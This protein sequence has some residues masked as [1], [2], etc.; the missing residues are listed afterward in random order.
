MRTLKK[1]LCLVLALVMVLGLCAVSVSAT[2][3]NDD[4]SIEHK[5]AVEVMSDLGVLN[6]MGDGT[7]APTDRVTR[8]Q[9]A[10]MITMILQ[11]DVD[12]SAF[13]GA[14]TDLTDINGHWAEAY[15][16][17]CVSQGIVAGRGDGTFDPDNYVT[18]SEASKMLLVALGYNSDVR[19]YTG[20]QWQINVARDAQ[21]K[22]LYDDL[23][24]LEADKQITRDEAAQMNYNALQ[25]VRVI[26]SQTINAA[27]GEVSL[28]YVDANNNAAGDTLMEK[29][30][31]VHTYGDD[32]SDKY[33]TNVEYQ[34][35]GE[36]AGKYQL[37]VTAFGNGNTIIY[38]A[39]DYSDLLFQRVVLRIQD[40]HNS[41]WVADGAYV[42]N[43]NKDVVMSVTA[44]KDDAATD[45]YFYDQV[46]R[47]ADKTIKLAG[48][49]YSLDDPVRVYTVSV[50]GNIAGPAACTGNIAGTILGLVS[51]QSLF[52]TLKLIDTDANGKYDRAVITAV[53]AAKVTYVSSSNII[54]SGTTYKSDDI[55]ADGVKKDDYVSIEWDFGA[56]KTAIKTLEK[57]TGK[58]TATSTAH[59]TDY[60][61]IDGEKLVDVQNTNASAVDGSASMSVDNTY[62][63]YVVNG[64][65]VY[66]K[67]SGSASVEDFVF[68][69][70]YNEGLAGLEAKIYHTDGTSEVVKVDTDYHDGSSGTQFKVDNA[71]VNLDQFYT[72]SRNSKGVRFTKLSTTEDATL[73]GYTG[74]TT[75]QTVANVSSKIATING[76]GID[77]DAVIFVYNGKYNG[78]NN[79]STQQTLS[80]TVEVITGKALKEKEARATTAGYINTTSGQY[81]THKV[82]GLVKVAYAAVNFDSTDTTTGT[83]WK[84]WS[85][86]KV[87]NGYALV[88]SDVT[89]L[90][91][92]TQYTIWDGEQNITVTDEGKLSPAK[93]DLV[94]YASI[95]SDN[96][97]KDAT[98]IALTHN[99]Y[100]SAGAG[101]Y[102]PVAMTGWEK[103]KGDTKL[104]VAATG[105]TIALPAYLD[106]ATDSDTIWLYMN[107]G[108]DEDADI[109]VTEAVD[110]ETAGDNY[111]VPIQ[112]MLVYTAAS[113]TAKVVVVDVANRLCADAATQV[114]FAN[115]T[116]M[117]YGYVTAIVDSDDNA[118]DTNT[119]LKPGD[120]IKV[121][122]TACK[123]NATTYLTTTAKVDLANATNLSAGTYSYVVTGL[124]APD[125]TMTVH[126]P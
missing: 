59:G 113:G 48:V 50:T 34:K 79:Y 74:V 10:K 15:I 83:T 13:L 97:I 2:E 35:D 49:N 60:A 64:A 9:M 107:S 102:F 101:A 126:D 29:T 80:G 37:T 72:I 31:A 122:V 22:K 81:L 33:L 57:Q 38:S 124:G 68:L 41:S 42:Y 100:Y 73:A 111:D 54:A 67:V 121:T 114:Q 32:G 23:T 1:T 75:G 11:G 46:G 106:I 88:V 94:S 55:A 117:G 53:N 86:V 78:N 5:E 70:Q 25:A 65:V 110:L 90:A 51:A 58:V 17:F 77:D 112:N 18:T 24:G 93:F 21:N 76:C 52:S 104:T 56:G 71:L 63:Y 98:K 27:T 125:L 26:E 66:A 119:K 12:A 109:G 7:F 3:Y 44:L 4:A 20:A 16:K 87:A 92:A 96:N 84:G 8:A 120:I 61:T 14:P 19:G 40:K 39:D 36:Q 91:D 123:T 105:W 103:V 116:K 45:V 95:D 47:D 85:N 89:T 69:A 82:N 108:A 30:Y 99:N 43:A 115:S 62:E 6:G 28:S 118:V